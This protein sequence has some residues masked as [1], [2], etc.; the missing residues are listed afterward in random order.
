V[1]KK[2]EALELRATQ[3]QYL[4][5]SLNDETF[6]VNILCVKEIVEYKHLTSVPQMPRFIEGVINLR[7]HVVP[8]I[9]LALR[10]GKEPATPQKRTCVVIIETSHEGSTAIVGVVVDSVSEVLDVAAAEIEP[11]PGFGTRMRPE[12]IA[13]MARLGSAFIILVDVDNVLSIT[14]MATLAITASELNGFVDR[15]ND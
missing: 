11:A 13:G 15:G 2:A 10:L 14:V 4:T 1:N 6:G 9:N 7:G 12:F 5:F 3:G 8:V